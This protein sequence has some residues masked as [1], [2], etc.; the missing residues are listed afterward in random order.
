MHMLSGFRIYSLFATS[1]LRRTNTSSNVRA[2]TRRLCPVERYCCETCARYT[3]RRRICHSQI[4]ARSRLG[5][6]SSPIARRARERERQN[7]CRSLQHSLIC[8]DNGC[9]ISDTGDDFPLP[10]ALSSL[11]VTHPRSCGDCE[12]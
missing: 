11:R 10:I 6:H 12:V 2:P 4:G 1:I 7:W 5:G 8:D 3:R 9:S